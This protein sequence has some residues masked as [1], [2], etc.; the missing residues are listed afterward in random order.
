METENILYENKT[1]KV[2]QTEDALGEDGKY[3]RPGYAVVHKNTGVIEHT[4]T[5]MPQA[6]FQADAF[7]GAMGQ[8]ASNASNDAEAIEGGDG[9]DILLQ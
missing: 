3:G 5:V 2:I 4:T 1:Y 8:L 9:E 7:E 6:L